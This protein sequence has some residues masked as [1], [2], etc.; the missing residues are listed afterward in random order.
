VINY[1]RKLYT[2]K[3][4]TY[5]YN[6]FLGDVMF[7]GRDKELERLNKAYNG[8]Q[9]EMVVIY[10]RRR[11][12]K[13]T[14]ITEFIKDKKAI[15]FSGLETSAKNN[16]ANL[17]QRIMEYVTGLENV[18]ISYDRFEDCFDNIYNLAANERLIFVIDEYPYL[19]AS[20][21]GI[22]SLLQQYIDLKFKKTKLFLIL[23]GSSMSFMEN[24]VLG[25]KSPLYGRR[26]MQLKINPFDFFESMQFHTGFSEEE[27]AIIYGIT[28]GIPQYLEQIDDKKT[29]RENII[30][31]FF[32]TSSYLF[33]EPSNLLK[34][35]LREP[36]L[37]NAIIEAVAEGSS[38][39]NEIA[40]KTGLDATLCNKYIKSLIELGIIKREKPAMEKNAKRS[41]YRLNDGMFRFWYRFIPQN[42]DRINNGRG[43]GVYEN[44]K[45]HISDFMGEVFEDICKQYL[46][47]L[48]R[49]GKLEFA[50]AE[51]WW[52]TNPQK[53]QQSEIDIIAYDEKKAIFCECKW[54]N[55]LVNES[56]IT[57]LIEK[58]AMFSFPVKEYM[59]FS[60]SGFEEECI[61]KY[62]NSHIVKLIS[63]DDM[64]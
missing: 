25:Y 60:K 45:S 15:Y 49:E 12:G 26:T 63:F 37:Y 58:S 39:M 30:D 28:G 6:L 40:T 59:I 48:N 8:N 29:L 9:F 41:I 19:A 24:Q 53:R 1:T 13:T 36:A 38:K 64:I 43:E 56:I 7:V 16:L 3:Y 61:N 22:S 27:S 51:K 46:W 57:E 33:E 55:E 35:E 52:G 20:Y 42:I 5:E 10:G 14:L 4:I 54:R 17:S 11:V 21:K 50:F 2:L 34:Q 47:K 18:K 23:C 44:I 31:N 32:N 62:S